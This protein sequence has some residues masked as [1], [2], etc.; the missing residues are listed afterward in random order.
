MSESIKPICFHA[1]RI[2]V[3]KPG[4]RKVGNIAVADPHRDK[5]FAVAEECIL[6]TVKH[7]EHQDRHGNTWK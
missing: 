2:Y 5:T 6:D 1:H 4:E 7:D 3:V